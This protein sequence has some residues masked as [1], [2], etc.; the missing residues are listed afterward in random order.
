MVPSA[1]DTYLCFHSKE[2]E[3]QVGVPRSGVRELATH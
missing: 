2:G 1:P 3:T